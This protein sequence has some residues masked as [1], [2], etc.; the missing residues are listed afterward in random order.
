MADFVVVVVEE[1]EAGEGLVAVGDVEKVAYLFAFVTALIHWRVFDVD[2]SE[3]CEL[4]HDLEVDLSVA[5]GGAFLLVVSLLGLVV[6]EEVDLE[7]VWW[8]FLLHDCLVEQIIVDVVFA[9]SGVLVHLVLLE[10][11]AVSITPITVLTALLVVVFAPIAVSVAPV[12]IFVL[13]VLFS[14]TVVVVASLATSVLLFIV[15]VSPIRF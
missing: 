15:V 14:V 6:E 13:S 4:L 9:E 5:E 10:V 2:G 7:L 12:V 3:F 1:A 11:G 8:V